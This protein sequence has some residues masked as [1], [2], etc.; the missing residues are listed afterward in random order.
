MLFFIAFGV[1]AVI[2]TFGD[3]EESDVNINII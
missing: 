2:I 3:K 1:C